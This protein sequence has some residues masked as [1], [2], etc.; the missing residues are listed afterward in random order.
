MSYSQEESS[1]G[2]NLSFLREPPVLTYYLSV[3]SQSQDSFS[4]ISFNDPA[5]CSLI[6]SLKDELEEM[7][8]VVEQQRDE[9]QAI[10]FTPNSSVGLRLINKCSAL[11]AEN[12]ELGRLLQQGTIEKYKMENNLQ[13]KLI[14]ELKSALNGEGL[15]IPMY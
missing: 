8:K 13:R 10:K 11:K 7:C 2:S 9:L 4:S 12:D 14:T 5:I 3:T 1:S 6:N 15:Q